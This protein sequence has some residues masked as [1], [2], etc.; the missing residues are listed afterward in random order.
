MSSIFISL[1]LSFSSGK[2][3]PG[4]ELR[5]A[6]RLLDLRRVRRHRQ[7]PQRRDLPGTE[8]A[9]R[10]QQGLESQSFRPV[11]ELDLLL[12]ALAGLTSS[13]RPMLLRKA[14]DVSMSSASWLT[15]TY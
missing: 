3:F 4:S 6:V 1:K 12:L 8:A 13:S 7:K 15:I 10:H 2:Q 11:A 14:D 5:L 9:Q